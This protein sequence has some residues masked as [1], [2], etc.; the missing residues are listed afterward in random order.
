MSLTNTSLCLS[1][2]VFE[3]EGPFLWATHLS[4]SPSETSIYSATATGN[5][6][7]TTGQ[8]GPHMDHPTAVHWDLILFFFLQHQRLFF[9]VFRLCVM[10]DVLTLASGGLFTLSINLWNSHGEQ[11]NCMSGVI[12]G[13]TKTIISH[14]IPSNSARIHH[15]RSLLHFLYDYVMGEHNSQLI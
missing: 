2:M 15:A 9:F 3:D 6:L 14:N 1:L 11:Q 12:S 5:S 13:N 8:C 7:A 10:I 4:P